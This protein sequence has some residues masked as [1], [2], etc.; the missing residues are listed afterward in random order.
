MLLMGP[1]IIFLLRV[2]ASLVIRPRIFKKSRPS[3]DIVHPDDRALVIRHLRQDLYYQHGSFLIFRII[4]QSG[5]NRWIAHVCQPVYS[6]EG[7]NLGRRVSNRDITL[8][9]KAET[10]KAQLEAQLRQAQKMEAIGTLAGG[11]AHDFNN[12]LSPI[13]MYTEIAMGSWAP[14]NS[15]RPLLEDVHKSS[16]KG[17]RL[18]QT[19]SHH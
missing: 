15:L 18:G 14:M 16:Q 10:E 8:Y 6:P 5:K 13:I 9:K 3:G 2:N 11:I 17:G 19:D 12:I 7:K 1:I 4:T